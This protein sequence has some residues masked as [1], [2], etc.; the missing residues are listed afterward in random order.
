MH[1]SWTTNNYQD[2]L[3]YLNS[4][5]EEKYKEF[6]EGLV[7]N[8]KYQMLGIRLPIMR[9]IA[10]EISKSNIIEFLNVSKDNYYEEVMIQGLV[11][12][13]IKDEELF[14]LM[15]RGIDQ[16][17]SKHLLIKGFLLNDMIELKEKINE[18]C[19]KYWR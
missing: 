11:I 12:S 18:I 7:L 4:I 14:Y 10:K 9:N 13:S 8:S 2:F 6:H 15:S 19:E 17:S 16:K 5:K 3:N 1:N